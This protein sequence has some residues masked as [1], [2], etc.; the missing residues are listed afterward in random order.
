VFGAVEEDILDVI[1][2]DFPEKVDDHLEECIQDWEM[3][4]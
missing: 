4:L 1:D 2:F 3:Y